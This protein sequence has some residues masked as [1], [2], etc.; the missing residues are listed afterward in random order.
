MVIEG[1]ASKRYIY[2]DGKGNAGWVLDLE[3]GEVC[4]M[5]RERKKKEKR[6]REREY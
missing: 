4:Y 1:E 6:E 2:I 3:W 5:C